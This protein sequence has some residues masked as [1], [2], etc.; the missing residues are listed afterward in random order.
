M[1]DKNTLETWKQ[2]AAYLNR[3]VRTCQRWEQEY[4]LPIKRYID[5]NKSRVFAY[6]S[7]IDNW[8]LSQKNKINKQKKHFFTPAKFPKYALHLAVICFFVLLVQL[9][10]P[11]TEKEIHGFKIEGSRIILLNPDQK[12]LGAYNTPYHN[13]DKSRYKAPENNRYPDFKTHKSYLIDDID[14]DGHK[15][16]IFVIRTT[17][18]HGENRLVCLSHKA[19]EKWS[20]TAGESKGF[21][22][23]QNFPYQHILGFDIIDMNKDGRQKI[24]VISNNKTHQQGLVTFLNFSGQPVGFSKF[25][26]E[27]TD[28]MYHSP[29]GLKRLLL[30]G[31]SIDHNPIC[32]V[33]DLMDQIETKG[34]EDQSPNQMSIIDQIIFPTNPDIQ[35]ECLSK[36]IPFEIRIEP[37]NKEPRLVFQNLVLYYLSSDLQLTDLRFSLRMQMKEQYKSNPHYL[38]SLKKNLLFEGLNISSPA[39]PP[40]SLSY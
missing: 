37:E 38:A 11:K 32:Q 6:K 27:I 9:V 30:A 33:I 20:F 24:L 8:L 10:L 15:E 16:L 39:S 1:N 3:R 19:K 18:S 23:F 29:N 2:I 36:N 12:N 40:Q 4:G 14:R 5:S 7:E 34:T 13:F 35:K 17:D 31:Y 21:S 28:F 26:G 22:F 25:K